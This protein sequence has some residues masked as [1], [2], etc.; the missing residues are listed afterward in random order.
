[1][2]KFL[3]SLNRDTDNPVEKLLDLPSTEYEAVLAKVE[4]L[5][6]PTTPAN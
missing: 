4:T 6:N 3:V 1:M 2:N 5:K